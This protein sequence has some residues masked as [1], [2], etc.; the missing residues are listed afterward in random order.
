MHLVGSYGLVYV[1]VPQVV[2]N[3]IYHDRSDFIL[4]VPV[5]RFGDSRDMEREITIENCGQKQLV[6]TSAFSM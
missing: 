3:Q 1:H 5:L 4:P 6:T 2:S